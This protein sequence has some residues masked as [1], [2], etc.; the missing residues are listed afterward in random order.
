V[1]PEQQ[2]SRLAWKVIGIVAGLDVLAVLISMLFGD[3]LPVFVWMV[4]L[5]ATPV[6]GLIAASIVSTRLQERA[7]RGDDEARDSAGHQTD[8]PQLQRLLSRAPH[9]VPDCR[10]LGARD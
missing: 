8:C 7:E 1:T 2:G 10:S 9:S 3:G 5:L 6:L 4:S